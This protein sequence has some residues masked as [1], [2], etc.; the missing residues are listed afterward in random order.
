MRATNLTQSETDIK[1]S[2]NLAKDVHE[3][4]ART[5][6]V[7]RRGY[8][9][10]NGQRVVGYCLLLLLGCFPARAYPPSPYFLVYGMVRDQYGTPLK[11]AQVQIILESLEGSQTKAFLQPNL[12]IGLN[13]QL[14]VPLDTQLKPELYRPN[15]L[16]VGDGFKMYVVIGNTTNV[17]I[18]HA[19]SPINVGQPAQ[20]MQI[21][22]FLGVDSNG[23]GIPDAWELAFLAALGSDLTLADLNADLDLANSGRTLLEEYLRGTYAFDLNG[24]FD[25][26][27]VAY[28]G[29][30][31]LLELPAVI[32]QSYFVL[33][34][35]D[36]RQWTVLPFK[37]P[38]E[39][40]SAEIRTNYL[41]TATQ[42]LQ[43]QVVQSGQ[44]PRM[45]F[46]QI[47]Q[48]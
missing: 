43:I 31:P 29:G 2:R 12:A 13:Y 25:V 33:G 3:V 26:R 5:A 10:G 4:P 15:A 45:Q 24:P 27:M 22:L 47:G 9:I 44:I 16:A 11:N 37:L 18:V 20:M 35:L 17:P 40:G 39:G 8:L 41:S 42:V 30:A 21:D 34:S 7:A 36:L 19:A 1:V 32:Q 23:D 28:N 6:A 46:F 48:R 14:R 38:S